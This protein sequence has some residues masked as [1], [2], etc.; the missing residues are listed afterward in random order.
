MSRKPALFNEALAGFF[1]ATEGIAR[2]RAEAGRVPTST[3]RRPTHGEGMV[4]GNPL[5]GGPPDDAAPDRDWIAASPDRHPIPE[6]T[7]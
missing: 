1:R 3:Q 6:E 5:A 7:R 4:V 2:Q